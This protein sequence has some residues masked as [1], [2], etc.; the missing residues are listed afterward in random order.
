[1]RQ[2]I[3]IIHRYYIWLYHNVCT[4]LLHLLSTSISNNSYTRFVDQ[5]FS[6][7]SFVACFADNSIHQSRDPNFEIAKM[8]IEHGA[9][10]NAEDNYGRTPIYYADAG[11]SNKMVR[12]LVKDAKADLNH[13]DRQGRPPLH[14]A[15]EQGAK[16]LVNALIANGA[17][18]N[19]TIL[20]N[21]TALHLV[22]LSE[23]SMSTVNC[24][25]AIEISFFMD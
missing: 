6:S 22:A 7:L 19:Q 14:A 11:Y 8:L 16:S 9:N 2:S 18:V 4:H 1:M 10:V 24:L 12:F 13:R 23:K 5:F 20:N 25:N 21:Q 17:N 15:A 3:K